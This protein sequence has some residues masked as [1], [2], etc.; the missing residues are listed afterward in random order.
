[1]V[2]EPSD[3]LKEGTVREDDEG[4]EMADLAWR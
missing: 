4:M 1:M 3:S 2:W